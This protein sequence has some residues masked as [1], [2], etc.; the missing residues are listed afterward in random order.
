MTEENSSFSASCEE[1]REQLRNEA[2]EKAGL[3]AEDI[4]NG[5]KI[6]EK[7]S[8]SWR[9]GRVKY[10][11]NNRYLQQLLMLTFSMARSCTSSTT[12]MRSMSKSPTGHH[13]STS[14]L[15]LVAFRTQN[16]HLNEPS[17]PSCSRDPG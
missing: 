15:T 7:R 16:Y 13:W 6:L 12:C 10:R 11:I 17:G 8:L 2:M 3:T 4:E 5:I 9:T 14:E 1:T